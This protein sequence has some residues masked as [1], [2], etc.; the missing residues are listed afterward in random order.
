[1]DRNQIIGFV[2][3]L[4]VMLGWSE[5]YIKPKMEQEALVKRTEDSLKRI[6]QESRTDTSLTTIIKSSADSIATDTSKVLVALDR[7]TQSYYLK[8]DLA[9][10]VLSSKGGFIQSANLHHFKKISRDAQRNEI[11]SDLLLLQDPSNKF[12]FNIKTAKGNI[13]TSTLDFQ[14]KESGNDKLILEAQLP[15]GGMITQAYQ[16]KQDDYTIQ[17]QFSTQNLTPTDEVT[18]VWENHLDK[19]ETNSTYE[20]SYSSLY[21]KESSSNAKY[22]SCTSSDVREGKKQIEW[23]SNS[24]QFFNSSL[25]PSQP[26][27]SGKFETEMAPENSN[28]LKTLRSTVSFPSGLVDGKNFEMKLYVG[29]NEYNR[30]HAIGNNLEDV[31]SYGW[32]VFGTINKYLIRPLFS[33]LNNILGSKGIII[34]LMTLLVKLLVFPLSY[35]MLQSQAKMM[36]LKPEI[37]KVKARLKDDMQQQQVETMKLYNE[38]GVNP[39]GGCFPLLLQTPIWIALYRFFPATIDFRQESFLW[40]K[41]LTSFD[42]FISLPFSIPFFGDTLSLF[43]ILWVISTIIFTYYNSKTTDFSANPSMLYMQYLM[44]LFFWVMFNKTAA[45]LTCY[46]FFSNLLNIGQTIMGKTLLF[47]TDKLRASLELNKQKPKKK[48]GWQQKMEEMMKE[49]QRIELEKQKAQKKK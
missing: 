43:A 45:G 44:P 34:I 49:R 15:E 1:M 13:N 31:I 12:Y 25:I 16:L 21:Y 17:Y 35:K 14:A 6:P 8:N 48:G 4:L 19:L 36:A 10:Y 9:T 38:F 28:V 42:E 29:P 24:N 40:A 39:L 5:F 30:L 33:F 23:L 22:C 18:L 26:F 41:D 20:R 46:M 27:S 2:L 37:D 32:S 3:I 7:P 11:K 47:D